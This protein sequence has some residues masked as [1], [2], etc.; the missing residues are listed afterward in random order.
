MECAGKLDERTG[1]QHID[2]HASPQH[3]DASQSSEQRMTSLM[4]EHGR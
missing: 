4:D 2:E 1:H 3:W